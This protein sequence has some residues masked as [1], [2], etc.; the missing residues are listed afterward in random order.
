M[1]TNVAAAVKKQ[2]QKTNKD[3]AYIS[4]QSVGTLTWKKKKKKKHVYFTFRYSNALSEWILLIFKLSPE[5]R[6]SCEEIIDA[7]VADHAI[8]FRS[9]EINIVK[10]HKLKFD[11]SKLQTH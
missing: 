4:C 7:T 2:K 3:F 6:S 1:L 5:H 8:H 9:Q 11:S 10:F